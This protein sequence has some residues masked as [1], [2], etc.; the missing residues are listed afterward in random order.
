MSKR[1][2]TFFTS[3]LLANLALSQ[4]IL[5]QETFDGNVSNW[6]LESTP[7]SKSNPTPPGIAGLTYGTNGSCNNYWVINAAHTPD[8]NNNYL[9]HRG[10]CN[11]M[12]N[13]T[14]G[15][16]N[17][18]L[19]ITY[20]ACAPVNGTE[21]APPDSGDAYAWMSSA[22]N[23]EQFAYY[24]A[25]INTIGVCKAELEC[26]VYLGGDDLNPGNTD[27]SIL[28]SPD[29][30]TTWKVLINDIATDLTTPSGTPI[31]D[32]ATAGSCKEWTFIRIPLPNDAVGIP[33]LRIGFRWRN[34]NPDPPANYTLS[35]G[36]NIDNIRI[37]SKDFVAAIVIDS[38][39]PCLS[40]T[41][42]F[43]ASFIYQAYDIDYTT[44][45]PT[46]T[47]PT[48]SYQW[49][50]SPATV[51]FVN[52]TTPTDSAIAV[53]FNAPGTYTVTLTVTQTSGSCAGFSKTYDTTITVLPQCLPF[54]AFEASATEI[55]A[56]TPTPAVG[57]DT[58]VQLFDKSLS[59]LPITGWQWNI[60]GPGTVTFL[61]GTNANSQNPIVSFSAPGTYTVQLT[62]TNS[63]GTGDTIITNYIS[64]IDCQ[65]NTVSGGGNV[66]V[67]TLDSVTFNSGFWP[68]SWGT[69]GGNSDA[70][71]IVNNN[72]NTSWGNI[73]AQPPQIAGAPNSNYAHITC[74]NIFCSLLGY[75]GM[76]VYYD[77]S[78]FSPQTVYLSSDVYNVST[79][80]SIR[81]QYWYLVGGVP[82]NDYGFLEYSING[83]TTWTPLGTP[84]VNQLTWTQRSHTL[85]LAALGNPTT[86]QFRWGF[87]ISHAAIGYD[88]PLCLDDIII[89]AFSPVGGGANGIFTCPVAPF[90]CVGD[91]INVTF[92]GRGTFN[93]GNLFIV[94]LSDQTGSFASPINLDTL[95]WSGTD[96]TNLTIPVVIPPVAACNVKGY[97]I[98]VIS[99]DP[100]YNAPPDVSDNGDNITI[101]CPPQNLTLS[102]DT[103]ACVGD[104]LPY[105]AQAN[106][107]TTFT[108]QITNGQLLSGQGTDSAL[109][110]WNT[111]DTAMVMVIAENACG[112]IK[113]SLN[114]SVGTPPLPPTLSG[115]TNLCVGA[116]QTYN[117]TLQNN[118]TYTWTVSGGTIQ[119]GQGTPTI[120]VQWNTAGSGWVKLVVS[121]GCGSDSTLLPVWI[122]QPPSAITIQG[123]QQ[124]ICPGDTF[125]YI[126]TPIPNTT[127][128]WSAT[129]GTIVFGQGNST[130]GI[131]WNTLG[132]QTL[133]VTVTN[134]CGSSN[135]TLNVDVG[136]SITITGF[137][138][139]TICVD[140]T[141]TTTT[142]THSVDPITGATYTWNVLSGGTI[143]ST[144]N[145]NVTVNWNNSAASYQLQLQ[146]TTACGIKDT[147]FNLTREEQPQL[148]NVTGNLSVCKGQTENYSVTLTSSTTNVNYLWQLGQNLGSPSSGSGTNATI[149]W[150]FG[151]QDTLYF[152]ASSACGSDTSYAVITIDSITPVNA[153]TGDTL[154]CAPTTQSYSVPNLSG[155][156]YTWNI[157]PTLS[158]TGQGT[159]T[160]QLNANQTGTY[161]LSISITQTCGSQTLDTTITIDT[162]PELSA[163]TGNTLVC[164]GQTET[165]QSVLANTPLYAT[166]TW[167][168]T[169]SLGSPNNGSNN[170]ATIT[171]NLS[172]NDTLVFIV[173]NACGVATAQLPIVVQTIEAVSP[174]NGDTTVCINTTSTYQI[175]PLT[176]NVTYQWSITPTTTFT[177]QGTNAIQVQ[178]NQP[179]TYTIALQVQQPCTTITQ[180]LQVVVQRDPTLQLTGTT[181]ACSGDTLTYSIVPSDG[182]TNVQWSVTGG[183]LLNSNDSSAQ[184]VW[185]MV[186]NAT[187]SVQATGKWCNTPQ[188][189]T[190]NIIVEE[191]I[192]ADFIVS[193]YLACIGTPLQF[194]NLSNPTTATWQWDFGDG[195]TSTQMSPSYTYS[196]PG[197]YTV[198]LTATKGNCQ[199]TAQAVLTVLDYPTIDLVADP[200]IVYT[201]EPSQITAF[202]SGADTLYWNLYG[203]WETMLPPFSSRTFL[204]K[205]PGDYWIYAI[206]VNAAGC[207]SADSVLVRV[208]ERARIY[209]PTAFTPNGQPP[210]DYFEVIA[211]GVYDYKVM[212]YDRW[213]NELVLLNAG[214]RWD[215]TVNGQPAPEGVYV[216]YVKAED[217]KGNLIERVGTVT[218]IR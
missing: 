192:T 170:S 93:P 33:N 51:T 92:N 202:V 95:A 6:V 160:I 55:C 147:I 141:T 40:K 5:W 151:G 47:Y 84:L 163:I 186:G 63:D 78:S 107:A 173:Q 74:N 181:T 3:I 42:F 205:V 137:D 215:G 109:V 25:D 28:Y 48:Y 88:P 199:D 201:E 58:I 43:N 75:T 65:C 209:I 183:S 101:A 142:L 81:I 4:T 46:Y 66:Q 49:S 114:V 13:P 134:A 214:E 27:R 71:W 96:P 77:N 18:S 12:P 155:A 52:G 196:T 127:Y 116:T 99:T 9:G 121:N 150:N 132:T 159:N 148:S 36:F 158:F 8:P 140:P 210:N 68:T 19:H 61:N 24:N 153:I 98:R 89:H 139:D 133:S 177:G 90:V 115:N 54:A 50:F 146:V 35:S 208:R 91:T 85:D 172:G 62:V 178:W 69:Q 103:I 38:L 126:A 217:K 169:Q 67:T 149:T 105:N 161:V 80:D 86:I 124:N 213:G 194:I 7:G 72:Y 70:D 189:Q 44:S 102:G 195:G 212:I 179:G 17:K 120:T 143:V 136:S 119:S 188:Q 16:N 129:G 174:I 204:H 125:L 100:A 123:P 166:T 185:N 117:T 104:A 200:N 211:V 171:W 198:V 20:R 135:A 197:T 37:V 79:Y 87:Q 97:R 76:A 110:A 152:I 191:G 11:N 175:T 60:T 53:N 165:Y 73:A 15:L 10:I 112:K 106:N 34:T 206:V 138:P 190:L 30:G 23:S 29:G 64:V 59:V 157:T 94:Q 131:V 144:N 176:G 216:V 108:W 83:G 26:W 2:T 128:T 118:V 113:D 193:D 184:V 180:Q 167:Q 39:P 218:L 31:Y 187:L 162:I 1:I 111:A 207:R 32:P 168:L 45:P 22:C 14:G 154:L 82:G 203:T 156:T 130:I 145:N 57:A 122:E 182:F 164:P 21:P 41:S 56:T